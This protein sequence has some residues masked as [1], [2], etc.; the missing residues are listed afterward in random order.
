[1]SLVQNTILSWRALLA[2]THNGISRSYVVFRNKKIPRWVFMLS[3]PSLVYLYSL[4]FYRKVVKKPEVYFNDKSPR[5][6]EIYESM[7]DILET[8]YFPTLWAANRHL[9]TY[10]G[11][12]FRTNPSIDFKRYIEQKYIKRFNAYCVNLGR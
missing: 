2:K 3:I 5:M 6:Q 9:N 7:K 8:K 12:V 1:M 11:S 4:Y 10:I